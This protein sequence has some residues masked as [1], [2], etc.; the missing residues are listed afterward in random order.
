MFQGLEMYYGKA[1]RVIWFQWHVSTLKGCPHA[2]QGAGLEGFHS[3]VFVQLIRVYYR[4]GSLHAGH[5]VLC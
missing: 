4:I 1:W 2:I 5:I 3:N